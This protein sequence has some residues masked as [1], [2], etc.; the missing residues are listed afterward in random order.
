MHRHRGIQEGPDSLTDCV[1]GGSREI[2]TLELNEFENGVTSGLKKQYPSS[3]C[4]LYLVLIPLGEFFCHGVQCTLA[5]PTH[6]LCCLDE[7]LGYRSLRNWI[8]V[9]KSES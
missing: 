7:M 9:L 3:G 6:S 2:V 5:L 4:F 1:L 8:M